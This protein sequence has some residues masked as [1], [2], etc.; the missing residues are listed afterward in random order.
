MPTSVYISRGENSGSEPGDLQPAYRAWA[1]AL[2]FQSA[3]EAGEVKQAAAAIRATAAIARI[4]PSVSYNQELS[5]DTSSFLS[6][7]RSDLLGLYFPPKWSEDLLDH[8]SDRRFDRDLV[9][10]LILPCAAPLVDVHVSKMTEVLASTPSAL[11]NAI[12]AF[13]SED[14]DLYVKSLDTRPGATLSKDWE[15]IIPKSELK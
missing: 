15:I 10:E 1:D 6:A 11:L 3:R 7:A 9:E 5:M 4:E 13:F 14:V 12:C 8:L 2:I